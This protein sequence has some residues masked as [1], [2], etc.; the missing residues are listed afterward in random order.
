MTFR[1]TFRLVFAP[2]FALLVLVALPSLQACSD[3]GFTSG[4]Q[5]GS[6][7]SEG[8][9]P[10]CNDGE[11]RCFSKS[12]RVCQGSAWV[13]LGRCSQEQICV[14]DLGCVECLPSGGGTACKGNDVYQCNTNGTFGAL[15]QQCLTEACTNGS[16][17]QSKCSAESQLIYVV[18]DTYNLLSF[19]P[20][21][22]KF[23]QI[24][25]L[26]CPAGKSW[27]A[28]GGDTSTPFSMSVDR[29]ARAWVLYDGG[30]IFWVD[31]KTAACQPSGFVK[32]SAG[33]ELF[34]MGFVSDEPGSAAEKLYIFGG[35]ADAIENGNLATIDPKTQTITTIGKLAIS[36]Q[37]PEM[38]GTGNAKLFGFF[39]DGSQSIVAE[40]DKTTGAF[41]NTWKTPVAGDV[42][43]WAFA[44]WG[45]RFY[46]FVTIVEGLFDTNSQVLRLDPG[47]GEV[48]II[49]QKL[50]NIIVGA[51]VS[52]CAPTI[53]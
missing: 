48:K 17:G 45:G 52:T 10:P 8:G 51:G 35:K 31:T 42:Q 47:T 33:Y 26:S 39:P 12:H 2:L 28:R 43:A 27:P 37:S 9:L 20:T 29:Q 53:D 15:V 50:P 23:T 25:K 16:C 21:T 41:V 1:P 3:D 36:G 24:G 18:S 44:H 5:D 4:K 32:G 49:T 22:A 14:D 19:S 38:T 7:G 46:I 40:I 13:E 11:K 30:E 34:G 6:V